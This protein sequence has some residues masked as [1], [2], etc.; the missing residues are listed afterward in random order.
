MTEILLA[1]LMPPRAGKGIINR[2]RL[3]NLLHGFE[4]RK[5][6]LLQAPAGYGKTVLMLQQRRPLV[7]VSS[8]AGLLPPYLP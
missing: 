5:L 6:T 4:E 3:I 2:P 7:G 8:F 1:K